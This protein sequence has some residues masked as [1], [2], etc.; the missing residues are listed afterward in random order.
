MNRINDLSIGQGLA[1]NDRD[2]AFIVFTC[3]IFIHFVF[4]VYKCFFLIAVTVMI[5]SL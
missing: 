4:Y 2:L 3:F 5:I 1:V